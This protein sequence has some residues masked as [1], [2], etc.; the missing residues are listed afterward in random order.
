MAL[1][2]RSSLRAAV[3]VDIVG[4]TQM[5]ELI[6]DTAHIV[7]NNVFKGIVEKLCRTYSGVL[8]ND[9]GD[10]GF[11]HF[12]SAVD[13][14]RFLLDL[15]QELGARVW[16]TDKTLQVRANGAITIGE[17][18][19]GKGLQGATPIGRLA[20]K[21]SRLLG[22]AYRGSILTSQEIKESVEGLL[23]EHKGS[24]AIQKQK[25]RWF[26]HGYFNFTEFGILNV[27]EVRLS[28]ASYQKPYHINSASKGVEQVEVATDRSGMLQAVR[29]AQLL[30]GRLLGKLEDEYRAMLVQMRFLA[31]N[32][33]TM[34]LNSA[35]QLN[36]L[37]RCYL[38]FVQKYVEIYVGGR[39]ISSVK[40]P[41]K[42]N[43][44]CIYPPSLT[45]AEMRTELDFLP[46]SPN[47]SYVGRAYQRNDF[48]FVPDYKKDRNAPQWPV[49]IRAAIENN[50]VQGF[51]ICPVRCQAQFGG[52]SA[53]AGK[54]QPVALL[55][56]HLFEK[57]L[58][59]DT[60]STRRV[61]GLLADLLGFVV[62][63]NACFEHSMAGDLKRAQSAVASIRTA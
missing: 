63:L 50:G 8:G 24:R 1:S 19:T 43:F 2:T 32:L 11:V 56:L 13:G 7:R 54:A 6:G 55:K 21:T 23:K 15:Q 25:L 57:N 39:V 4:S 17:V 37:S 42:R 22:L 3:M 40:V 38:A 34:G 62:Q 9:F 12:A 10:G 48:L 20:N 18:A 29:T 26:D 35:A 28:G 16:G 44:R 33:E 30:D 14:V 31:A 47:H 58:I 53:I 61:L 5:N 46:K 52:A 41:S 49:K 45:P 60:A 51:A 27:F 59:R 36:A